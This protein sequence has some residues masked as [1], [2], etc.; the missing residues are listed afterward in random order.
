MPL[1]GHRKFKHKTASGHG[2]MTKCPAY[3]SILKDAQGN[4]VVQISKGSVDLAY[5][6]RFS[7]FWGGF[8][9]SESVKSAIFD[10]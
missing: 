9:L 8:P 7:A 4:K 10:A 5:F 2:I 3:Y 6:F 1:K